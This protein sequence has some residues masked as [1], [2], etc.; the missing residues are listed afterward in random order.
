MSYVLKKWIFYPWRIFDFC[1]P[2]KSPTKQLPRYMEVGG[3]PKMDPKLGPRSRVNS[4]RNLPKIERKT[5]P[6]PVT[7]G[8]KTDKRLKAERDAIK[9]L[10]GKLTQIYK[11]VPL[12]N[13]VNARE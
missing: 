2:T 12:E 11:R 3:G 8:K 13:S 9:S 7:S 4:V 10:R 1:S 6:P 5:G